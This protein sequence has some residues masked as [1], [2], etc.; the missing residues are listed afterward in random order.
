M[1]TTSIDQVEISFLKGQLA[2]AKQDLTLARAENEI[3]AET[4]DNVQ[5][6]TDQRDAAQGICRVL[7]F[8]I[9]A[10]VLVI[11]SKSKWVSPC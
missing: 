9:A 5:V 6:I 8:I 1:T 3:L 2:K 10:L 11:V 7:L 4:A